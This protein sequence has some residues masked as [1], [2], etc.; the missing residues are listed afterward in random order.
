MSRLTIT[1]SE[2]RHRALKEAAARRGQTIGEIVD[3]SLEYYGI[4]T[5]QTAAEL[6]SRARA[7][8][9]LTADDAMNIASEETRR[10]RNKQ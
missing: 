4:K 9:G 2:Q 10:Q 7:T 3:A 1:L 5:S 6:V 8:V